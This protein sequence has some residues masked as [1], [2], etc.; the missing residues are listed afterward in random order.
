MTPTPRDTH[1]NQ[2]Q[3]R[4]FKLRHLSSRFPRSASP[5]LHNLIDR[6]RKRTNTPRRRDL[7]FCHVFHPVTL[8]TRSAPNQNNPKKTISNRS[9]VVESN[10]HLI[11]T[12]IPAPI[13]V[14][15]HK[16][17]IP[18]PT[19]YRNL[20]PGGVPSSSWGA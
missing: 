6:N 18:A 4:R 5:L 20:R 17:M 10:C 12:Q 16:R 8:A 1:T 19:T 3:E 2:L 15:N 7:S 11:S 9:L 13:S 14:N